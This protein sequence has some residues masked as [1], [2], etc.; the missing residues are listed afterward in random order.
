[1]FEPERN[2]N[3]N[4]NRIK[5]L[6]VYLYIIINVLLGLIITI[7]YKPRKWFGDVTR[8]TTTCNIKFVMFNDNN[9]STQNR[10]T[11]VL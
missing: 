5:F 9:I 1:M 2:N 3:I 8:P 7:F 6:F 10:D 4:I 11:L